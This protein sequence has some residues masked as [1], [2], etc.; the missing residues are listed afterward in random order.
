[1]AARTRPGPKPDGFYQVLAKD[2]CDAD[3]LI[4]VADTGSSFI[5]GP[6]HNATWSS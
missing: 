4:Y 3:P 5:A 2:N 1:V 6:F